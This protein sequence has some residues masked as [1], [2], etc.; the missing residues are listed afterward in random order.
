MKE[1]RIYQLLKEGEV[2][3]NARANRDI[4]RN[5]KG[6][7][8]LIF[9]DQ[10]GK[11]LEGLEVEACQKSIDFNF[12]ANIFMLGEYEDPA[13]NHAYEEEFCKVFNSA[14]IPLYW[15]GTEPVQN[16]LRYDVGTPRDVYRRPP[17]DGVVKFCKEHNLRM[18]GHPLFW[19][20]FVPAWLP[21]NF[22]E[23]KP[24]IV[25]RF[26]EIA[27]R[28][29]DVVERFDV[30]NE[31]SR[32]YD[33]YRRDVRRN[34]KYLIPEDDYCVWAFDLAN[35]YFPSNTLILNDTVG[36]AFADFRGKYSGYYLNIKD[37]LGRGV[38]IDEVGMQCHLGEEG[39]E[40]VNC[41]ERLY[42]V[43]DTYADLGK[44]IN[45]SEISIPSEFGGQVDE[46]LQAMATES[47]YKT[48]F[49]HASVS[50]ITWWNLPDDGVL[51]TKRIA[52]GEN[53]PSTGL[54]GTDYHEKEAYKV[55]DRLINKEWKTN[56]TF[57]AANGVGN[58]RGF[59]GDYVLKIRKGDKQAEVKLCLNQSL[60]KVRNIT[61]EW[62]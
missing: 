31:P 25:K 34:V 56:T 9:W 16:Y 36:A 10:E 55:L 32:I 51:T 49:S 61:V 58:F 11:L 44:P 18:K 59:Y 1:S 13:K 47:L 29:K 17:V 20:E 26:A 21:E 57:G 23:L 42:E 38:R 28:Y 53:I 62:K 33:C 3:A 40:N 60:P 52:P 37:L 12:G 15:E 22:Q 2:G 19:H 14:A 54:L 8:E 50:G 4:E 43:L 41:A 48:C 7:F 35:R 27:E 6:D 46:E 45:I 39:L 24:L 5:R 30:V